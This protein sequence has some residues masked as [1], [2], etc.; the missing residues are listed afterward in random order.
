MEPLPQLHDA[1]TDIS[2]DFIVG[3]PE[4]CRPPRGRPYNAIFVVVDWYT[5]MAR[6]FKCRDTVDAA[7]LAEII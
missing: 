4:S 3:L 2:M 5:K 6:Y 1:W 7:D